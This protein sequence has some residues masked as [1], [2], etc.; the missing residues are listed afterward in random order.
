MGYFCFPL[1]RATCVLSVTNPCIGDCGFSRGL[2]GLDST[3]GYVPNSARTMAAAKAQRPGL[4]PSSPTAFTAHACHGRLGFA[5]NGADPGE[6]GLANQLA[7]RAAGS[8]P[9]PFAWE[10]LTARVFGYVSLRQ[11]WGHRAG[12]NLAVGTLPGWGAAGRGRCPAG[13]QEL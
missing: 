11:D 10:F 6:V 2:K 12:Q 3:Q 7:G 4:P 1:F 13:P 8:A 5:P 9:S